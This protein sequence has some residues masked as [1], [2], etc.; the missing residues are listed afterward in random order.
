MAQASSGVV[1]LAVVSGRCDTNNV[2]TDR[3]WLLPVIDEV[4]PHA[5]ATGE[6]PPSFYDRS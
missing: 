6:N 3:P 4:A 2:L 5:T 1:L